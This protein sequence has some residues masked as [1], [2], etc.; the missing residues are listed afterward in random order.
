M[1]EKMTNRLYCIYSGKYISRSDSSVEHIIPLSLGGSDDFT[2]MVDRN[3]NSI[4]GSSVDGKIANDPLVKLNAIKNNFSGH[5][6]KAPRLDLKKSKIGDKPVIVSF[7]N[8]GLELFD[9]IHKKTINHSA[10]INSQLIIDTLIRIKFVSKVALAAG[11]FVYGDTFVKHA[12]HESLRKVV[13]SKNLRN[14]KLE[15]IRFYD[16]LHKVEEKD[17]GIHQLEELHIKYLNGSAVIF[18]L[19]NVNIIAHVGIGGQYIGTVNFKAESEKFPNDGD[20]RLGRVLVC[21]NGKL[22]QKSY[23]SSIY[24]MNKELKIVDIDDSQLDI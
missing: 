23:W 3:L 2:I 5:S 9:P 8:K 14:E 12:D 18:M 21:K 7:T 4:V 19:S 24:D 20:Y 11:Y 1:E 13:F 22:H 10:T 15:G 17:R 6:G 16:N